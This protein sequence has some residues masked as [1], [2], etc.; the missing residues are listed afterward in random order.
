MSHVLVAHVTKL[1]PI[2]RVLVAHVTKL[3]PPGSECAPTGGCLAACERATSSALA[4]DALEKCRGAC[5]DACT[6]PDASGKFSCVVY[7]DDLTNPSPGTAGVGTGVGKTT[8]GTLVG[9]TGTAG[10]G[11]GSRRSVD[12]ELVKNAAGGVGGAPAAKG[13]GSGGSMGRV[14]SASSQIRRPPPPRTR[15]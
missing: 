8:A 4:D 5:S 1:T 3:T 2:S 15:D 7:P 9:E 12:V 6:K 13:G 10:T 11:T 14:D